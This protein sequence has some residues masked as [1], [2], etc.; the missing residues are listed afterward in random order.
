VKQS[1][2]IPRSFEV[3]DNAP[4]PGVLCRIAKEVQERARRAYKRFQENPNHPGLR[5]KKVCDDPTVY[6][7][8]ISQNHRALGAL[9]HDQITWFWIGSHE[10]YEHVLRQ[11]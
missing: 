2:S 1:H 6:A 7:V 9:E 10:E 4:I 5:F 11:L 8:R 3:I